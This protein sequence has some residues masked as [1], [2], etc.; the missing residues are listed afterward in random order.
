MC[1]KIDKCCP[2]V[3]VSPCLRVFSVL[4]FCFKWYLPFLFLN[5]NIPISPFILA[6]LSKRLIIQCLWEHVFPR[7]H[8]THLLS[9]NMTPWS[10]RYCNSLCISLHQYPHALCN[11]HIA[12]NCMRGVT[13]LFDPVNSIADGC[14]HLYLCYNI[15]VPWVIWWS[16]W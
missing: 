3:A 9:G 4:F 1:Q 7:D 13:V 6:C 16:V 2:P 5:I 14:L 8:M 15:V 10:I 11:I 12:Y